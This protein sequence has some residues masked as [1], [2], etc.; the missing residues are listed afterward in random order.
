MTDLQWA[1]LWF[2]YLPL[3]AILSLV[4]GVLWRGER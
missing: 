4:A 1:K 2:V 3:A